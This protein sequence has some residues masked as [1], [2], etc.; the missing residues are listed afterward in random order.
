MHSLRIS[1]LTLMVL[2]LGILFTVSV[3]GQ[4][5]TAPLIS[6]EPTDRG[7]SYLIDLGLIQTFPTMTS[8]TDPHFKV[9][10]YTFDFEGLQNEGED[11]N[12]ALQD[13]INSGLISLDS[14]TLFLTSLGTLE[15][16]TTDEGGI[17]ETE[18][19]PINGLANFDRVRE[20]SKRNITTYV[21]EGG[22]ITIGDLQIFDF[23]LDTGPTINGNLTVSPS[24]ED[25]EKLE[26]RLMIIGD[27]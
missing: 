3:Y 22:G 8:S 25:P 5:E 23:G 11:R 15:V 19:M 12:Y 26:G 4:L 16:E 14:D 13:K 6:D 27:S 9:T 24:A 18:I 2:G 7:G 21:L 10:N 1:F 20:D 17:T